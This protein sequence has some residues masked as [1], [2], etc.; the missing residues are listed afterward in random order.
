[1]SKSGGNL[2]RWRRDGKELF[3][4][5]GGSGRLMAVSVTLSPAFQAGIPK[6]LFQF[7]QGPGAYDVTADGQKFI[8]FAFETAASDGAP[9]PI[10]VVLNWTALLKK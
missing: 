9:S 7:P 3:Y 6:V 1:V 8:R 2:P 5:S 10:T 4:V